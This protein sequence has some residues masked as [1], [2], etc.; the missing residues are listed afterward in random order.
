MS[1]KK[2]KKTKGASRTAK[3]AKPKS[4]GPRQCSVCK[5]KGHNARSHEPGGLL[6]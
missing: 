1:K 3:A 5:K 4:G 6:A 2:V